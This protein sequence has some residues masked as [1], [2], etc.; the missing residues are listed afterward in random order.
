M[1]ILR[2]AIL[3]AITLSILLYKPRR[4]SPLQAVNELRRARPELRAQTIGY[5]GRLDPLAEGLLLLLV[6]D[7][8]SHIRELRAL[9]KT[10]E[11]DV[12]FGLSTDSYDLARRLNDHVVPTSATRVTSL[13]TEPRLPIS[14]W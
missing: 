3:N 11:I 10:Y 6:G 14:W 5:A 9:D 12:L 8:N 13:M 1:Q 4:S 2:D 7:E